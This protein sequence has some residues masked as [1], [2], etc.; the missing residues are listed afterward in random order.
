MAITAMIRAIEHAGVLFHREMRIAMDED[1]VPEDVVGAGER[2][3]EFSELECGGLASTLKNVGRSSC[4]TWINSSARA[5]VSSSTA[6]TAATESPTKRTL[7]AHR[8]SSSC[9]TGN[10]PVCLTGG[11]SAAVIT[12]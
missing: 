1:G 7:S 10:T 2:R 11:R 3:V 12:P 9:P 8:T 5:P 4:S 6:A